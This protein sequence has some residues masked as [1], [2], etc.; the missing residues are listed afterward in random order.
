MK[1]NWMKKLSAALCAA[2]LFASGLAVNVNAADTPTITPFGPADYETLSGKD[3]TPDPNTSEEE[4]AKFNG[5]IVVTKKTSD[6]AGSKFE[7]GA[8]PVKG[9]DISAVR[10]GKYATVENGDTTSIMI[11]IK[12]ALVSKLYNEEEINKAI[13]DGKMFEYTDVSDRTA[14]YYMTSDYYA[15]DFNISMKEAGNALDVEEFWEYTT[16]TENNKQYVTETTDDNGK[17]TFPITPDQLG[18]YLISEVSVSEAQKQ[19]NGQWTNVLFSQKQYPYLVS[20]PYAV[21]NDKGD[22]T[23]EWSKDVTARAKNEDTELSSSKKIERNNTNFSEALDAQYDTDVTHVGDTVEFTLYGDIPYIEAHEKVE[24]YVI[25]DELTVGL[26][27][28]SF[29]DKTVLDGNYPIKVTDTDNREYI[30][31]TDYTVAIANVTENSGYDKA[32]TIT[33]KESGLEKLSLTATRDGDSKKETDLNY[34][35]D[36][37]EQVIVRY[38]TT[39]NSNAIV[40]TAG[41]PNRMKLDLR[42]AGSGTISTDWDKVTEFIFSM[43]SK[44]TFDGEFTSDDKT[45]AEA[46]TFEL[47]LNANGKDQPVSLSSVNGVDGKPILGRYIFNNEATDGKATPITLDAT[48]KFS[49]KG[50]PTSDEGTTLYLKETTT[51]NGY[52]KLTKLIPIKLVANP[53]Q[54]IEGADSTSKDG[55]DGT[56]LA[57]TDTVAGSTVNNKPAQIISVNGEGVAVS[58]GETGDTSG[59]SFTVNNTSGFQLPSTG[60]MGIWMFVIGGMAVIG[61]GLLYY[62]RNKSAE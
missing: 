29:V 55:Y 60:G 54:S 28:P 18:I 62:R 8:V 32:F 38:T 50:V 17:A 59:I 20:V 27:M 34:D 52:N 7:D 51:A 37:K 14:Y 11:G 36:K 12:Q 61:C 42:A 4:L 15:T 41:N 56:L 22:F 45:N 3:F 57:S 2:T 49:I 46:V 31:G 21:Q 26:D 5:S 53:D 33:F 48:G 40:G 24:S 1:K 6:V 9:V 30:F 43:E 44:K 35:K 25:S 13:T 23:G 10:V 58:A 16:D 39:V 19:V 47:Y